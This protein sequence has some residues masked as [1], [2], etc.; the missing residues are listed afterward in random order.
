MISEDFQLR[1]GLTV[2][3]SIL[4]QEKNDI[5][6]IPNK[7][8]TRRGT[9][10]YVQVLQD[11]VTTERLIKTGISDWQSTEVTEGLSEG[12]QVLVPQATTSTSS[13]SQQKPPG[14]PIPFFGPPPRPK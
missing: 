12:E 9:E 8:I 5:L 3:V 11:G 1:E 7:A 10:S 6:L 13:S 4:V 14:P 2:T